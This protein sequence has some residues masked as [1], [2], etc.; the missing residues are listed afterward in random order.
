MRI[1]KYTNSKGRNMGKNK[2]HGFLQNRSDY[3]R[4]V[5]FN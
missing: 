3:D 2:I 4:N 5:L 1:E